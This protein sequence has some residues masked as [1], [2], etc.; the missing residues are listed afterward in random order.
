MIL[1]MAFSLLS[2][3]IYLTAGAHVTSTIEIKKQRR[4]EPEIFL[5]ILFV[6]CSFGLIDPD[7]GYAPRD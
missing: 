7:P 4:L 5:L 3:K 6:S 1:V 2:E